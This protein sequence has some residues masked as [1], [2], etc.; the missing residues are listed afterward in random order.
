MPL[1]VLIL[2]TAATEADDK[3]LQKNPKHAGIE[4]LSA[5]GVL[6]DK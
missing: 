2:S 6:L 3:T 5:L 1:L 4:L